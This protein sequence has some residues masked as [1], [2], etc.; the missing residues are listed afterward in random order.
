MVASAKAELMRP[1]EEIRGAEF[2]GAPITD[3]FAGDIILE[4]ES[5]GPLAPPPMTGLRAMAA[6]GHSLPNRSRAFTFS[7]D[8]KSARIYQRS[9]GLRDQKLQYAPPIPNYAISSAQPIPPGYVTHA[10]DAC[11]QIDYQW[12]S[13]REPLDWGNGGEYGEEWS[14][15]H[16]RFRNGLYKM[17]CWYEQKGVPTDGPD[18]KPDDEAADTELIVILVT[19]GAGCN[20]LIGAIT[21]A[22][23]LLDVGVASLSMAV[24]KDTS[25]QQ[26]NAAPAPPTRSRRDSLDRGISKDFDMKVIASTEHLRGASNPLGLNSPR[27]GRSPA[28]ASRRLVGPESE[29]GFSIGD[30]LSWRPSSSHGIGRSSGDRSHAASL[31][32]PPPT[33]LWRVGSRYSRD[34]NGDSSDQDSLPNFGN[35]GVP[36]SSAASRENSQ[37]ESSDGDSGTSSLWTPGQLTMQPGL[38]GSGAS[39]GAPDAAAHKRRWTEEW[40][41]IL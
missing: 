11:V 19:H 27:L 5:I 12:D 40:S 15:M 21:N 22:P 23:V 39:F 20:A 1:A 16:R 13:L 10:R 9:A 8:M 6:L 25:G 33:G 26:A 30:P 31:S 35:G 24:R 17:L 28:F 32:G 29:D 37:R 34:E 3:P 2:L 41:K 7:S 14:S 4:D 38:W 18:A 36:G